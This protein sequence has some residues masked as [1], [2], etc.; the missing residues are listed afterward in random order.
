MLYLFCCSFTFSDCIDLFGEETVQP[1]SKDDSV[2]CE[3]QFSK[4]VPLED[5]EVINLAFCFSSVIAMNYHTRLS[6]RC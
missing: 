3:T 1:I 6:S 4:V 2:I 5:G